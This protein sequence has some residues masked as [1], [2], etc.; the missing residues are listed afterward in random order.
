VH[1]YGQRGGHCPEELLNLG[2]ET[3][4][5]PSFLAPIVRPDVPEVSVIHMNAVYM[6]RVDV[7]PEGVF[8]QMSYTSQY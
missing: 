7:D 5:A 6:R 3:V 2:L 4:N 8:F 1:A